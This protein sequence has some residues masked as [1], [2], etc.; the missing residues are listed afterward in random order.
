MKIYRN[1][2]A[3]ELTEEEI[4]EAYNEKQK[5]YNMED[6][7]SRADEMGVN[8]TD[9]DVS[10][11]AQELETVLGHNDAYWDCYW[12]TVEEVIEEYQREQIQARLKA[13]I[14]EA[15]N[16]LF[17]WHQDTNNI[18][19]GDISPQDAFVLHDIQDQ[20]AELIIRVGE[21]NKR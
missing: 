4:R 7:I 3:I 15:V 12:A 2:V 16:E 6:I 8:W 9:D 18:P 14:H 1:G 19:A 17:L 20:L 5:A 21:E 11:L 10:M 13:K